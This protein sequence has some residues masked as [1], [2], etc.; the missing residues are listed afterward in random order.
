LAVVPAAALLLC[1]LLLLLMLLF[2]RCCGWPSCGW[3][4]AVVAVADAA[5]MAAADAG[6]CWA[7]LS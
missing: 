7:S 5:G 3:L 4:A 6:L 1:L 2:E